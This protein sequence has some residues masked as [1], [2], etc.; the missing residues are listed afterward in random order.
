MR[1]LERKWRLRVQKCDI[2]IREFEITYLRSRLKYS[3]HTCQKAMYVTSKEKCKF[4]NFTPNQNK[5]R[6]L[7]KRCRLSVMSHRGRS[8]RK[9]RTW[10]ALTKPG[11]YLDYNGST[12]D[13]IKYE[14]RK[15]K[16]KELARQP[17]SNPSTWYSSTARLAI[18][19]GH[20][21]HQFAARP[22]ELR[23]IRIHEWKAHDKAHQLVWWSEFNFFG[24]FFEK[25][26]KNG[27]TS[28]DPHTVGCA[29]PKAIIR[30]SEVFLRCLSLA[31]NYF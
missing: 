9:R 7:E 27:L 11:F 17:S 19:N 14:F 1:Q 25:I 10:V 13:A 2:K 6:P 21:N 3:N 15:Q 28:F 29:P 5:V 26:D 23:Q 20:T 30:R 18:R 16:Q 24:S 31:T 4:S 22:R 12:T 8:L